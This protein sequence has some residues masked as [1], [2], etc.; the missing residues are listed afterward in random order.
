MTKS[1]RHDG[2]CAESIGTSMPCKLDIIMVAHSR[3]DTR[4]LENNTTASISVLYI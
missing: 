1:V 2:L 4:S 3:S